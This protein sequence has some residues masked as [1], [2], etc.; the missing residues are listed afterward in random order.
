MLFEHYNYLHLCAI[1]L[2]VQ[3]Q[4]PNL[5]NGE[6]PISLQMTEASLLSQELAQIALHLPLT[7]S[8]TFPWLDLLVYLFNTRTDPCWHGPSNL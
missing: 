5:P 4:I 2:E 7:H 6:Y 8:S 3:V 1:F